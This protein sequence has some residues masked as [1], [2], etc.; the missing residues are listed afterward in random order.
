MKHPLLESVNIKKPFCLNKLA[1]Y[2]IFTCSF[3]IS[4]TFVNA[5]ECTF[6]D[7]RICDIDIKLYKYTQGHKVAY[8][9][10]STTS[11][12]IP[13]ETEWVIGA[14]DIIHLGD[15]KLLTIDELMFVIAH[16]Y[17]HSLRQHA[18]RLL[19]SLAPTADH[20]LSDIDLFKKYGNRFDDAATEVFYEQEYDADTFAVGVLNY[21]NIDPIKA[22]RGLLLVNVNSKTHPSKRL[23]LEHIKQVQRTIQTRKLADTTSSLP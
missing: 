21:Y 19:E 16:E 12:N 6:K 22:M 17:C 10:L 15:T 13:S 14:P 4:T 8:S 5:N 11:L 9:E 23:R 3:L 20:L 18:R 2:L 1:K 7:S